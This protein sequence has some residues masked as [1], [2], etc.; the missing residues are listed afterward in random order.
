MA[1]VAR[2]FFLTGLTSPL[3]PHR[4]KCEKQGNIFF[5]TFLILILINYLDIVPHLPPMYPYPLPHCHKILQKKEARS[6]CHIIRKTDLYNHS[7]KGNNLSHFVKWLSSLL[8]RK[9]IIR[10]NCSIS[11]TYLMNDFKDNSVVTV[12]NSCIAIPIGR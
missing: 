6:F 9:A 10:S 11:H 12:W 8:E 3:P 7:N 5:L 2:Q 4:H 1:Q